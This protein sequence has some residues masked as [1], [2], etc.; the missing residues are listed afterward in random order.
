MNDIGLKYFW[1]QY[2]GCSVRRK[3]YMLKR[4]LKFAFKRAWIG[5]DPIDVFD[6]NSRFQKRTILALEELKKKHYG[7]WLV[8]KES[9][10]YELIGEP[11]FNEFN[12]AIK[13]FNKGDIELIIDIMIWHLKMM[14]E[15]FVEKQL[16]GNCVYDDNYEPKGIEDLKKIGY[17]MEQNKRCFM[18]LFN[19]FYWDMRD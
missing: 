13:I 6:F 4:E 8:P 9:E 14:D 3:L 15:D 19:L 11:Q 18:K 16:Y 17:I 10:Y 7:L 12:D 5:Y 1:E 2:E